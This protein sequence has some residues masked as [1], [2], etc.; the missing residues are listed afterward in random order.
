MY[1]S[2]FSLRELCQSSTAAKHGIQNIPSWSQ[3][4]N[5]KRICLQILQPLRQ[6]YGKP[7]TVNSAYRS[8]E[9]NVLVKG[10][11]FSDHLDGNAIDFTAGSKEEN[12]KLFEWLKNSGLVWHQ[13][14]DERDYSWIHVSLRPSGNRKQILHL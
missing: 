12:K 2:N 4:E 7:I 10:A 1:P 13:L 11:N 8:H 14:I 9:L 6:W 5:L 3:V